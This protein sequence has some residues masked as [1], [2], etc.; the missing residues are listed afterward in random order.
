MQ[1]VIFRKY[2]EFLPRFLPQCYDLISICQT[3]LN[4][5]VELPETLFNGYTL[6]P[7][8]LEPHKYPSFID[9]FVN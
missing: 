8:N 5:T 2:K 7:T 4:D 3:S 1:Q 9:I 6:V